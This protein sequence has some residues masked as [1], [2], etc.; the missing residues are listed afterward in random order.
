MQDPIFVVPTPPS[1]ER[2]L[3]LYHQ[4]ELRDPDR[5]AK[6][7]P[8]RHAKFGTI[9]GRVCESDQVNQKKQ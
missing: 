4:N 7:K 8:K 6:V 2:R 5:V 1:P 3:G 9:N